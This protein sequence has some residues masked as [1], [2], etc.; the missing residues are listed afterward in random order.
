MSMKRNVNYSVFTLALFSSVSALA[1]QVAVEEQQ[2]SVTEP[3]PFKLEVPK[4]SGFANIRYQYNDKDD[5]NSFDIRRA[6]LSASGKLHQKLEYK[7]QAEYETSVKILDAY[8]NYKVHPS[9]N[10]QVGQFKAPFAQESYISPTALVTI[11]NHT[12]ITKLNGYKDESGVASLANGRD[13]GLQFHGGFIKSKGGYSIINYKVGIFNGS[14]INTTDNNKKQDVGGNLVIRPA[15]ALSF[16]GGYYEG[17]YYGTNPANK[18]DEEKADHVRNRANV[19]VKYDDKKLLIQ[20]EYVYGHT[21][22]LKGQGA[23]V[24]AAYTIGKKWQPLLSYDY[25]Q[26]DNHESA[27]TQ[28]YQVGVNYSPIKNFRIQGAYSHEKSTGAG[29]VNK[30]TVQ[31]TFQF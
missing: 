13:V 5:A 29:D 1:Q 16:T 9:F 20:S 17:S 7:I 21:S 10:I 25:Y 14:G 24:L 18:E 26:K 28:T 6:R 27:D 19:G 4:F 11:D 12:V 15:D 30:A 31:A 23:Y 2:S 8:F 22:T 3:A